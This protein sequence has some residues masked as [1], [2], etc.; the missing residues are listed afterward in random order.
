MSWRGNKK[1][2]ADRKALIPE[3]HRQREDARQLFGAFC[4]S[5]RVAGYASMSHM[6]NGSTIQNRSGMT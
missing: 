5:P 6:A 1:G 2:L 4:T 3:R